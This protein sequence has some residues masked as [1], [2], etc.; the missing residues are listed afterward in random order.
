MGGRGGKAGGKDVDMPYDFYIG[1]YEV[2]QEEWVKV[3]KT[4]PSSFQRTGLERNKVTD[5]EVDELK[6]FPVDNVSWNSCQTFIARLNELETAKRWKYRL[7]TETEWEYACRG[8]PMMDRV[9]STFSFYLEQPLNSLSPT[10]A[11]SSQSGLG[12]TCKV[13]SYAPN[14]LG[15]YDM[16]G[17]V[18]EW[19]DNVPNPR[20]AQRV[21]RGGSYR[22]ASDF[23][24]AAH[25]GGLSPSYESSDHGLR[26]ARVPVGVKLSNDA[27]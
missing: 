19:C 24:Q 18:W 27:K 20:I 12:R 4:N 5:I 9:Q 13:G 14:R 23:S 17:N 2:T 16:H 6:R 1:R 8:G 10:Q 25:S 21:H 3:M 11:N 22:Y 7:P 26:L 15:L